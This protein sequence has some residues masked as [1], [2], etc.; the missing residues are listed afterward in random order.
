MQVQAKTSEDIQ[1]DRVTLLSESSLD[2][3]LLWQVGMGW[4]VPVAA[5][6]NRPILLKIRFSQTALLPVVPHSIPS[7]RQRPGHLLQ[8]ST[9]GSHPPNR[10]HHRCHTH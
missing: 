1:L 7:L 2:F 5:G 3:R 8:R 6:N 10:L 9:L 4:L